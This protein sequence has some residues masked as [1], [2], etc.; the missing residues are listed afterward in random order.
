M[1]PI[2][3]TCSAVLL[4]IG[5]DA[6]EDPV[7]HTRRW[8]GGFYRVSITPM[9]RLKDQLDAIRARAQEQP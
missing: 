7:G 8:N 6:L 9:D 3:D 4:D 2:L 1:E 5:Q